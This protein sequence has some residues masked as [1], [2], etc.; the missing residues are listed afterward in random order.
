MFEKNKQKR[1]DLN[2]FLENSKELLAFY[3]IENNKQNVN[4]IILNLFQIPKMIGKY[5]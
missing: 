1:M 2:L 5:Y 4:S 3:N